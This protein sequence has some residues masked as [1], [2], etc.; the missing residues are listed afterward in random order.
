MAKYILFVVKWGRRDGNAKVAPQSVK[1]SCSLGLFCDSWE[2]V[3]VEGTI[4]V[5]SF[6]INPASCWMHGL[7]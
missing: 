3:S 2:P 1:M 5:P 4:V 7:L 6:C